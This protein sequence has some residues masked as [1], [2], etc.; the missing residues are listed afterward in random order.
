MKNSGFLRYILPIALLLVILIALILSD[1]DKTGDT[2]NLDNIHEVTVKEV[3][4]GTTYT[5]LN[6]TDKKDKYWAAISKQA[7][8]KGDKFYLS[9]YLQM[10]DFYSKELDRT[11]PVIYFINEA[12]RDGEMQSGMT[13]SS[14]AMNKPVNTID[15]KIKIDPARD[16]IT[17]ADLF[18]APDK[19][20]GK[21]IIVR[22][23]VVK[24]NNEIMG[25]NWVHLQDGSQANGKF[26]LTLTT[27]IK[28]T[29]GATF[30]SASNAITCIFS[31]IFFCQSTYLY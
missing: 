9:D 6:V 2:I 5:Y 29:A 27:P 7:A 15:D 8:E 3:I 25:R 13:N 20:S 22:G 4:Q 23:K 30:P 31:T 12:S 1:G 11:F 17:I 14:P 26:D 19:Y 21:N 10:I 28:L 18:E 24:V 16:G